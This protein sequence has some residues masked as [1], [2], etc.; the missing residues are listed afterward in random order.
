M[1]ILGK[2]CGFGLTVALV[3]QAVGVFMHYDMIFGVLG[4]IELLLMAVILIVD[5][6]IIYRKDDENE[7]ED[8]QQN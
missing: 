6:E 8:E 2:I 1:R 7:V 3:F 4:G 5:T